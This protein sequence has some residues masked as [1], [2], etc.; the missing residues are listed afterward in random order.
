DLGFNQRFRNKVDT[1]LG[2]LRGDFEEVFQ[3]GS[4]RLNNDIEQ[5]MFS[6]LEVLTPLSTAVILVCLFLM[7]RLVLGAVEPMLSAGLSIL[8][9]FGFMGAC[10]FP[11][12]ILTAIVPSLVIVIGRAE[13]THL[14]SEYMHGIAATRDRQKAI[15]YMARKIGLPIFI[16]SATTALGFFSN[17]ITDIALIQQFSYVTG[18]AMLANLVSTVLVVP[19]SL[20]L[21]GPRQP[22]QSH[23]EE[24]KVSVLTAWLA[25][26]IIVLTDRHATTIIVFMSAVIVVFGALATTVRVNNDPLSYFRRDAPIVRDSATVHRDLSGMQIFYIALTADRPDAFRDPAYLKKV[27]AVQRY[28]DKSGQLDK[29]VSLADHVAWVNREMHDGDASHLNV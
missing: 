10:G 15:H 20:S 17:A 25:E 16:N 13:D 19:L 1:L 4:P 24:G 26:K 27:E 12:T 29:S 11:L 5:A 3:I 7:L 9:T 6:D 28:L 23:A 2:S 14:I 8:W 22:V 21:V 18:F